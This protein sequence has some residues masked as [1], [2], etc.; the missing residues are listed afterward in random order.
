[1]THQKSLFTPLFF[2]EIFISQFKQFTLKFITINPSAEPI[3]PVIVL[4]NRY[5]LIFP[6]EYPSIHIIL[7]PHQNILKQL[8]SNPSSYP[9]NRIT[10]SPH[11]HSLLHFIYL[12]LIIRTNKSDYTTTPSAEPITVY[13]P[14]PH[15]Y[16]QEIRLSRQPISSAYYSLFTVN[17]SAEPRNKIIKSPHQPSLLQFISRQPISISKKSDYPV[18]PS[19]DP[20]TVY[21]TSPYQHIQ[22]TRL[23]RHPIRRAYCPLYCLEKSFLVNEHSWKYS[24]FTTTPSADPIA[25]FIFWRNLYQYIKCFDTTVYSYYPISISYCPHYCLDKSWSVNWNSWHHSLFTINPSAEPNVPVIV[26]W[27][28]HQAFVPSEEPLYIFI[29]INHHS[30]YIISFLIFQ[31]NLAL[32]EKSDNSFCSHIY[33]NCY[34]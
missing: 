26:C 6:S 19:A 2:G 7:S 27:N 28:H 23:S 11:Q 3:V 32:I 20:I 5:Q 22:E 30:C 33:N 21:L 18:T 4:I 9:I 13:L 34:I 25:P 24:L 15:H 16:I 31:N 10:P 8:F 29:F 12:N 17:Q 14:S 1:M